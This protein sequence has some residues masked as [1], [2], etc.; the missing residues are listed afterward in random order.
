MHEDLKTW[1]QNV[2]IPLDQNVLIPFVIN[3]YIGNIGT[4]W[5]KKI[6]MKAWYN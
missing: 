4:F 1:A 5:D 3:I 6:C 2:L